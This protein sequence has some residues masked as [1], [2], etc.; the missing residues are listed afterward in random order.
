MSG[1]IKQRT[2]KRQ[3][4]KKEQVKNMEKDDI[5][6]LVLQAAQ[7]NKAAFGALYEETGRTVYFS[8]LKLLGDPQLAEDITQETYLTAL[9]KLGTLAQPENF[10]AWVNRIGINLCKMHFRNNS[11]P[12]DNSEEIIEEIP[13][14]G[15]IPE[16]Y[17]SNDAKRKIIMDIID[18]VLT[19]EQRRSVILYYFDMLTVPDI[20]EVMNCTTGTVTSR[21]SA[22]R[23]KIKEAVLIYEENN[24]DR[25]HA[26]VP[27]F[28]LSKLLNKEASNTVLP[29]L[30]VFTGSASAANAVPDSVTTT[31]TISGGKGMFSTVKAKVIAGVCAAAVVGG[32][33]TAAVVLSSNGSKDNDND[34]GV[35]VVTESQQSSE[36][37]SAAD[38]K[39]DTAGDN[40]DKYWITGFKGSDPSDTLPQDIF[41]S[42]ISVP[43]D[44]SAI[45][46]GNAAM[47][48]YGDDIGKS[49]DIMSID[50]MVGENTNVEITF[51]SSDESHTKYDLISGNPFDR[52]ASVADI[53]KENSWSV[54]IPLEEAVDT[55]DWEYESYGSYSNKEDLDKIIDKMGCPTSI[56]MNSEYDGM[57]DYKCYTM[58]WENVDYTISL[59]VVETYSNYEEYDVVLDDFSVSD[60][61]YYSKNYPQEEIHEKDGE[62]VFTSEYTGI[63][64]PGESTVNTDENRVKVYDDLK[65][66]DLTSDAALPKDISVSYKGVDHV[67][68]GT[69]LIDDVR[70]EM[71]DTPDDE[72][73][74]ALCYG[75]TSST[76]DNII[77]F[78]FWLNSDHTLHKIRMSF[79]TESDCSIFGITKNSTPEEM[80][81]ILGTPEVSDRNGKDQ[82]LDWKSDSMSVN[83]YYY[84]GVLQSIQAYFES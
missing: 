20:A 54:T 36:S 6:K 55:S 61:T 31:K 70:K 53:L 75:K 56:Y 43:V 33:I 68:T 13:D 51:V 49:G 65:A 37:N 28:I 69:E 76:M 17:V 15:L 59:T 24:N 57:D 8:C 82:F 66:L 50:K 30:T 79:T 83:A 58:Y 9:Q 11:A 62:A 12:E 64:T 78:D 67:F 72:Y 32:G 84:D 18:T 21:L 63:T 77:I 71:V 23:K 46:G 34:D 45:D 60:F 44:L 40:S 80:A 73:D 42:K 5:K 39:A 41:G 14:E 4:G 1:L 25:L 35:V 29:K 74:S 7:G 38:N 27:V 2:R 10:P 47:E 52:D 26:V 48:L 3:F 81:A 22:A 16:E 19:E